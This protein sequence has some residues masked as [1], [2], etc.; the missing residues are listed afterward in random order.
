MALTPWWQRIVPHS[1]KMKGWK[2]G[3]S[4]YL[5]QNLSNVLAGRLKW[6]V[7]S[8]RGESRTAL[9]FHSVTLVSPLATGSAMQR[10]IISRAC[11]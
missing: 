11:S 9:H 1:S 7:Q 5:N 10:Y 3:P 4:H 6:S 2:I 8:E